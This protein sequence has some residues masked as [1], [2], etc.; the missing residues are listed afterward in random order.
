MRCEVTLN[1]YVEAVDGPDFE[2][3]WWCDSDEVDGFY[4]A[5]SNPTELLERAQDALREVLGDDEIEIKTVLGDIVDR[6]VPI[7]SEV[8]ATRNNTGSAKVEE[9]EEPKLIQAAS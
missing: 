4:S 6:S 3:V 7:D 1:V 9:S 5:A 8:T 2:V